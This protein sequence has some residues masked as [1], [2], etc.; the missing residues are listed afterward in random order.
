MKKILRR[1]DCDW[2][3]LANKRE[4]FILKEYANIS[5]MC[6]IGNI[7]SFYLYIGFLIFPSLQRFIQ[8]IFGVV[9]YN[10]LILP[11]RFD[12]FMKNRAGYYLG[13]CIQYA[14]III[15]CT[16]A[17]ANYTMFIVVILHACAL[18]NVVV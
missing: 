2:K 4:L 6:T 5:R 1:I 9:S 7:I 13:L 11:V 14:V 16:V 18:F 10:E 17:I 12:H 3:K 8:H 15:L